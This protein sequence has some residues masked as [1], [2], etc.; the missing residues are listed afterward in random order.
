VDSSSREEK[1]ENIAM[2]A[3]DNTNYSGNIKV[4]CSPP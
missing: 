3:P 2:G 1:T 4:H